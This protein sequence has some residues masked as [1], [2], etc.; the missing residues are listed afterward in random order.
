MTNN[1]K[2]NCPEDEELI[3]DIEKFGWVVMLIEET[4]YLPGFA[5][6]VGLWEKY[7]HPELITFG[8]K[9]NTM[10]EILNTGGELIKAGLSLGENKNYDNF[11]ENSS[12]RFLNVDK[13]NISDYFGYAMWFNNYKDFS[14]LQ[15]VWTDRNDK[16]PWE[17]GFEKEFER[18]Q[19]LLDRNADFKFMETKNLATFTTRQWMELKKTIIR[20]V[21]DHD[22]DW[23]FLTGDQMPEDIRLVCLEELV[24]RDPTLNDVF[25]LDYGE[26]AERTGIN[27]EWT[28]S[29]FE[30]EE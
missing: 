26:A 30:E 1:D 23:Q 4:D 24:K 14:A 15:L 2:H 16:F 11:F 25:N 8:L 29:V 19:P 20:V 27:S 17:P 22:G 5:Y 28:R 18:K 12:A 9:K 21:H 10:H 6:T 3:A 7:N 13:R